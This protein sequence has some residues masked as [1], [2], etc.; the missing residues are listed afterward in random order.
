ME[1]VS[2][3]DKARSLHI[4]FLV[5]ELLVLKNRC[6]GCIKSMFLEGIQ[7]EGCLIF[8]GDKHRSKERTSSI[9]LMGSRAKSMIVCK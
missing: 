7:D 1:W 2:F 4:L 3:L 6:Y 9:S 5:L 8:R